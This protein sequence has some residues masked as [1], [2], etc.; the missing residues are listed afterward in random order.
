[1]REALVLD[2]DGTLVHTEVVDHAIVVPGRTQN[3]YV[4]NQTVSTLFRLRRRF[5]IIIAT[6]RSWDG[7]KEVVSGL[8]NAGIRV[9][10]LVL[11]D[12]ALVGERTA[13]APLTCEVDWQSLRHLIQYDAIPFKWQSDFKGC[14]VARTETTQESTQLERDFREILKANLNL[15]VFRDGRKVYVTH[16]RATKLIALKTLL[17]DRFD[18]AVGVGDGFNDLCWLQEIGTPCTFGTAVT[19]VVKTVTANG[20]I[21]FTEASHSGINKVLREIELIHR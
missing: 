6:A 5:D 7:A 12:G 15:R 10:G 20:G 3:A 2:L 13:Y 16:A 14:L 21:F 4:S 17:G 8:E 19:D 9:S 18:T 11:E 1:M